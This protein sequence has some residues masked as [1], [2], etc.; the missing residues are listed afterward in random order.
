MDMCKHI[1]S[2]H[3]TNMPRT[4]RNVP[5]PRKY[6]KYA[7]AQPICL[8]LGH[9]LR[10]QRGYPQ[11]L[12]LAGISNETQMHSRYR[13]HTSTPLP[14]TPSH[15][16]CGRYPN[17]TLVAQGSRVQCPVQCSVHDAVAYVPHKV[18]QSVRS[19]PPEGPQK[20]TKV[21]EKRVL[22]K[23]VHYLQHSEE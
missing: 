14:S 17:R 16:T 8:C 18:Q 12:T 4:Y 13:F 21:Q 6:H 10:S 2:A 1:G 5:V 22:R 7:C 15:P 3:M 20:G 19:Q 9:C 23:K 11:Q